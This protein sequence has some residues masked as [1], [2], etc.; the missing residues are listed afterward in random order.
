MNLTHLEFIIS[1]NRYNEFIAISNDLHPLHVDE[2]FAKSKGF[3]S[4]VVQ[5]NLL[6]IFISYAIGMHI[7]LEEVMILK[8]LINYRNPIYIGDKLS[9]ELRIIETIDFIPGMELG[10]KFIR[11]NLLIADGRVLI[12]TKL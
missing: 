2:I 4:K 8:Q 10:F 6:N 5:G 7:G 9:L 1:E 11:K 3:K 12:K